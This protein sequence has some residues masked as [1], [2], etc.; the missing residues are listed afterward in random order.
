[1]ASR[2]IGA[3]SALAAV[4]VVASGAVVAEASADPAAPN[5]AVVLPAPSGPHDVGRTALH[6]VDADRPDPWFPDRRRELMVTVT[7]PASV[8]G[9]YARAH[10][11]STDAVPAVVDEAAAALNVPLESETLIGLRTNARDGAPV[12]AVADRSLPVVL[13]SPGMAVPRM[14]GTGEA[15]D[16]ASRGYVVVSIDHTYD[17][18]VVEFPGGR[19]AFGSDSSAD[20]EQSR[21]WRRTA[22]EARV[23]DTSFVLDELAVLADGGNPDAEQRRLPE[24]LGSALDLSRVGMFGHSLGGYTAVEAMVH[25][26]RI[27]AGVNLDGMIGDEDAL[28]AAAVEG[29]DRPILLMSSQQVSDAGGAKPSWNALWDNSCGWKR[30][31]ELVGAAHYSFTDLPSLAPPIVNEIAPEATAYFIGTIHPDRADRAVRAYV[32]AMFDRFLRDRPAPLLDGP[33]EA[34]PEVRVVR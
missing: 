16:L 20:P 7:Y 6:L 29:L 13:F 28:G 24:A 3:L 23:A 31:L 8:S 21:Q 26:N 17:A 32:A 1:M 34:F 4:A 33:D 9:N 12:I 25:D 14:F 30:E 27:D 22:L 2:R 18:Q 5:P 15:E 19:I 10:Y 11:V